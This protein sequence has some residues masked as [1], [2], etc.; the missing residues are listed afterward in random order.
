MRSVIR[1]FGPLVLWQYVVCVTLVTLYVPIALLALEN[2]WPRWL[3]S[4][5]AVV[6]LAGLSIFVLRDPI[7]R[8]IDRAALVEPDG[9]PP[10]KMRML[11]VERQFD[12]F[13]AA[14]LVSGLLAIFQSLSMVES[15]GMLNGLLAYLLAW[16]FMLLLPLMFWA[17]SR[18]A[19]QLPPSRGIPA[20][21]ITELWILPPDE[22]EEDG[23]ITVAVRV[24]GIRS[25]EEVVV[26]VIQ[27]QV[28]PGI[29]GGRRQWSV[30]VDGTPVGD[31]T[32]SWHHPRWW[33]PVDWIASPSSLFKGERV[34][35]R[36]VGSG[37][38]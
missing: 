5:G 33:P 4:R 16:H 36:P 35:F 38:H 27:S 17:R 29:D 28:L 13:L 6:A 25:L 7:F 20:S 11:R 21:G 12:V 26:A 18:D 34:T 31:L 9:A 14:C 10:R 19:K 22:D 37:R 2:T 3:L 15:A 1:R 23:P 32:Q 8:L 30:V 24:D